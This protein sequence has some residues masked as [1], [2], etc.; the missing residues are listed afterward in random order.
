[1]GG[2]R[3]GILFF[4]CGVCL[5]DVKEGFFWKKVRGGETLFL[6]EEIVFIKVR[7]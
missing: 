6:V 3:S 4:R 5:M 7:C 2:D 1:M